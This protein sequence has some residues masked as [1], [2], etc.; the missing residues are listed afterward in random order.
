[1][2]VAATTAIERHSESSNGSSHVTGDTSNQTTTQNTGNNTTQP[3][4]YQIEGQRPNKLYKDL[5][6]VPRFTCGAELRGRT[7]DTKEGE[8]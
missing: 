6:F 5:G 8:I 3:D 7:Q 4:R 1:M 2:T